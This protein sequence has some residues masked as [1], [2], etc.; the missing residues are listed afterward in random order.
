MDYIRGELDEAARADVRKLLEQ[1]AEAFALF[2]RLQRT[3]DVL[4]SLPQVNRTKEGATFKTNLPLTEPNASFVKD[5]ETE[6]KTRGWLSLIPFIAPNAGWVSAIRTEFSVRAVMGSLPL[7]TPNA[8]LIE[9]LR[10][11][12]GTRALMDS[13]PFIAPTPQWIRALREDFTVR[14]TVD[15]IPQLDVRPE[16]VA[17]L[18][19]EFKAREMV[20][21]IPTISDSEQLKR[22]L[23]LAL[24]EERQNSEADDPADAEEVLPALAASDSFRRRLFKK[25]FTS[26][27]KA[28]TTRAAKVDR[29]EYYWSSEVGRGLKK[30][31]RSMVATL[32]IHSVAIALMF[33]FVLN[34]DNVA[35]SYYVAQVSQDE[36]ARPV[37]PIGSPTRDIPVSDTTELIG[38]G[39]GDFVPPDSDDVIGI[40]SNAAEEAPPAD[41][42][43]PDTVEVV[44]ESRHTS[45][46]LADPA[47]RSDVAGY[48]RLRGLSRQAKVKYLGSEELYDELDG[49][50]LYLQRM[51]DPDGSWGHVGVDPLKIPR[52][53]EARQIAKIEMT[54]AA[55][56]AFLGDGHTSLA[57]PARYDV[58]V[59]RGIK[60]L[61][62]QQQDDGQI[63]PSSQGNVLIHSM[64]TLAL[65][66]E[67]GLT[68]A[69]H[70]KTP[71][72]KACRWLCAVRAVDN[73]GGFPWKVGGKA[74]MTTTVWA[75]MALTTARN[76]RVPPIDLPQQRVDELLEW[77]ERHTRGNK[78]TEFEGELLARTDVLPQSAAGA[79]SLFAVENGYELRGKKAL[80]VISKN[81]PDVSQDTE[82][83]RCDFRYLFFASM[84]QALGNQRGSRADEKWQEAFTDTVLESRIEE[85]GHEGSYLPRADYDSVY[86]R[87]LSTAYAALS[88]ENPYRISLFK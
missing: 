87:V 49:A 41:T 82:D 15:C 74:G 26:R 46:G 47:T 54:S 42:A 9:E 84:S 45:I 40:G 56:L 68:R 34:P 32:A 5:L 81:K 31:R 83:D 25:I 77:Y 18:R 4:S 2:E 1:D 35:D 28:P 80:R 73:S 3:F 66:E 71:L 33:F 48:F 67:F 6:F 16:F 63:G 37:L 61:I 39:L 43:K 79:M 70:L 22:R 53:A 14:S 20:S 10:F 59:R 65:V 27:P 17:A 64:A 21:S 19:E 62:A 50:L 86:G 72:R 12:F 13:I 7:L 85:G 24:F 36:F 23:K 57:S 44:P 69:E 76:V 88:I 11:Q 51:Q 55:L 29:K 30:S 8:V 75:Y 58:S 60:W 38:P 52:N 78:I